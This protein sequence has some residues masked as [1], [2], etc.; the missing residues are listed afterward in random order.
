VLAWPTHS[1]DNEIERDVK[2]WQSSRA[3]NF[4]AKWWNWKKNENI[5]KLRKKNKST[6][7]NSTDPPLT[8]YDR[9][10]KNKLSKEKPKKK[11][12]N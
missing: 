2:N 9:D 12:R 6:R 10:K 1:R 4:N 11:D 5:K 7:V 8:T 3:N